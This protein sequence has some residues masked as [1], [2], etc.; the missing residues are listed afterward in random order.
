MANYFSYLP[1]LQYGSLLKDQ[2]GSKKLRD[3]YSSISTLFEKYKVEGNDRPDQVAE[4]YYGSAEFDWVVLLSNNIIDIRSEWP[5]GESDL[6]TVLNNR[7]TQQELESIHHYETIEFRDFNNNLI[8][9][10]G[11]IVDDNFTVTY[12]K[13]GSLE[14]ISPIRSVSVFEHELR[15]ND[16][17]RNIQLIREDLLPTVIKDLKE[18]MRYTPNSNYIS[19]NLKKTEPTRITGK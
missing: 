14:R 3:D 15:L 16:K 1:N 5:I 12:T 7:Y 11:K 9:P 2:S 13:G 19:K 10:A 4:K 18:I 6:N 8:I 17:K